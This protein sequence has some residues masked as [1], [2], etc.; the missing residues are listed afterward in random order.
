MDLQE[1]N[2]RPRG[3][4]GYRNICPGWQHRQ[5]PAQIPTASCQAVAGGAE[6]KIWQREVPVTRPRQPPTVTG[7]LGLSSSCS[8]G[9]GD[10]GPQ[11]VKKPKPTWRS[12]KREFVPWTAQARSPGWH[13]RHPAGTLAQHPALL[14]PPVPST[15]L[16][17]AR[18]LSADAANP[19]PRGGIWS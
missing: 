3:C 11:L 15:L 10:F 5:D 8:H 18:L 6:G 7:A 14:R 4:R 1:R 12:G 2:P 13:L 17:F 19:T 16:P 9:A